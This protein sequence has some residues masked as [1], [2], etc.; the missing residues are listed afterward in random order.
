MLAA[1]LVT[2]TPSIAAKVKNADKV[3]GKH[4]VTANAPSASG[5]ARLVATDAAG[6]LPS[7]II[8]KVGDS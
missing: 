4:A 7:D 3:D 5:R 1:S 2:A 8:G 6:T